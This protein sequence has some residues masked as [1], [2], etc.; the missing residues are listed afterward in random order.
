MKRDLLMI[1]SGIV[2]TVMI[3]GWINLKINVN[4]LLINQSNI[5]NWIQRQEKLQQ[6][7]MPTEPP[8]Q[9]LMSHTK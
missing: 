2:I 9:S 5:I 6:N 7:A 8:A 1:L 3:I 4:T